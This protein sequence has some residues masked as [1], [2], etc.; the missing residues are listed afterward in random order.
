MS[1]ELV[2]FLEWDSDFFGK[3]IA[4]ANV[5]HL[6]PRSHIYLNDWCI[7]ENIDCLYFLADSNHQET[8]TT[9]EHNMFHFVDIRLTLAQQARLHDIRV[10]DHIHIRYAVDGDYDHLKTISKRAY[11]MS[12]FYT[13]EHFSEEDASRLYD[14]WL[15]NSIQT[16]YAETVMIA[17]LYEKPVGYVTCHLNKP[18]GEG[19]IG[20][21]GIAE[22]ARGNQIGQLLVNYAV[23]WFYSHNMPS[24]NVVTQG[25]NIAAQRL[26]QRCGFLTR[27]VELWY[28][29]WF[30]N[31]IS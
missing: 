30:T 27:S 5:T 8:I 17:D 4:R 25:R 9:L 12:R 31:P 18:E 24:V 29:K 21:V 10:P 7:K 14:I 26:Y 15:R 28:H 1:V 2:E 20:L 23:N 19:N 16:N 6:S 11:V 22:T 3:R 13:D